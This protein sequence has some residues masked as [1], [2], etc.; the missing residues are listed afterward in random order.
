MKKLYPLGLLACMDLVEMDERINCY[1]AALR[2]AEGEEASWLS[3][4]LQILE[5]QRDSSRREV[6]RLHLGAAAA[7]LLGKLGREIRNMSPR[8]AI[9]KARLTKTWNGFKDG[10]VAIYRTNSPPRSF[11]A[12][13]SRREAPALFG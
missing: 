4:R 5:P 11:E 2:T 13:P 3:Q 9:R 12:T 8:V 6:D 10:V 1:R 7:V